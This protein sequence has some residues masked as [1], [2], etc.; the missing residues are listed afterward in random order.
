MPARTRRRDTPERAEAER[1]AAVE[2]ERVK[3]NQTEAMTTQRRGSI[4]TSMPVSGEDI[5]QAKTAIEFD[6]M[7]R[8]ID[9]MPEGNAK[10]MMQGLLDRQRNQFESM[11]AQEADRGSMRSAIAAS[12]RR[13]FKGTKPSTDPV[14]YTHLTLPTKRIV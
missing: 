4:A 10:K 9:E 14:S 11:Q 1:K 13:E 2:R 8:R 7:Q 12:N 6:R 3:K 5:R